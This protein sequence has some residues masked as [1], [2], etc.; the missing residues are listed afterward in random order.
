VNL[1]LL[2][3]TFLSHFLTKI[4]HVFVPLIIYIYINVVCPS[5]LTCDA[6]IR[7]QLYE[8]ALA[9]TKKLKAD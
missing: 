2:R 4:L 7:E 9:C 8:V 3:F 6:V 1:G 5:R